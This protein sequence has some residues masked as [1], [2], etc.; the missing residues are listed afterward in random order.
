MDDLTEKSNKQ[1]LNQNDTLKQINDTKMQLNNLLE[2]ATQWSYIRSKAEW[3]EKGDR[4]SKFFMNL[5][6][7]RQS[8]NTINHI[9]TSNGNYVYN[10]NDIMKELSTFYENLFKSNKTSNE[11]VNQYFSKVTIDKKL[12]RCEKLLCDSQISQEELGKVVNNLKSN[13]S[14][15][16]DGLTPEFYKC[17]W[18]SISTPFCDMVNESFSKKT[19]PDSLT[20]A[21]ISLLHKKGE[22]YLLKNYRPISLTNYD[23]KIIAFALSYR[24]QKVLPS[25]IHKNQTAYI[26]KRFIGDNVR[27]IDDIIAYSEKYNNDGVILSLDFQKAFDTIEWNFM[28]KVLEKLNFGNDL[29]SWIE[30]LYQNANV[31]IKNNGY[32]SKKIFLERG[33]R[34][35]CPISSILFILCVEILAMHIRENNKIKGL[36]FEETEF[37]IS[38]YADDTVLLLR[39]LDSITEALNTINIFSTVAGPLLNLDKTEGLLLG[40]LRHLQVQTF[41]NINFNELSVKCLGIHIGHNKQI[42]DELNWNTK[43]TQFENTL[44]VWQKRKLNIFGKVTVINYICFPKLIYLC[45]VT[46]VPNKIIEKIEQLID[47]LCGMV[48]KVV[49][50]LINPIDNGGVNLVH[51]RSKI[52]SLKAQWLV[53]WLKDPLWKPIADSLLRKI[54][55]CLPML[56]HMNLKK[57]KDFP[58]LL[59]MPNFY[60]DVWSSYYTYKNIRPI[61]A[62]NDYDF[63][64]QVIW[65]N[66]I[67]KFQNKCL[68]FHNWINGGIIYVKDLFD[69]NGNFHCESYILNK[70]T[71]KRDWIREYTIVKKVLQHSL[72]QKQ[73]VE[74]GILQPTSHC[75]QT[76]PKMVTT[77]GPQ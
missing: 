17:F 69:A 7:K 10:Q 24:L 1:E 20:T 23:Y 70:I 57:L 36:L 6:N 27:T 72:L 38:Q 16:L 41:Q 50:S 71:D 28:H 11:N 61:A 35:G 3:C 5:E 59:E 74:K 60:Q 34:Q 42:C 58:V 54:R 46:S 39:D 67:F 31:V 19:L 40:N 45:S 64:T 12:D 52:Q 77:F 26:K 76:K 21:V 51:V 33:L 44:K 22:R 55:C 13:K 32:I 47:K 30:I 25:L 15:G 14:P 63:L 2:T 68:S 18:K 73:A 37:K 66:Q 4:N 49:T 65:G 8:S 29:I 62:M 9:K 75:P 43:L 53:R 48:I 56:F